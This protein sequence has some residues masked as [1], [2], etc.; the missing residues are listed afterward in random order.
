MFH[1][2]I[3]FWTAASTTSSSEVASGR[4]DLS[5]VSGQGA[6][7][8]RMMNLFLDMAGL[9]FEKLITS[10]ELPAGVYNVT[11]EVRVSSQTL[12]QNA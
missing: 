12:Y 10:G 5:T 7:F 11:V 3:V 4:L 6:Q 1:S 9:E 8:D 2:L